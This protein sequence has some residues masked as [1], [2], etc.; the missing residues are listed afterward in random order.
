MGRIVPRCYGS[1][2]NLLGCR[3]LASTGM[4]QC[5]LCAKS[6][7]LVYGLQKLLSVLL[8]AEVLSLLAAKA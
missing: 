1:F 3:L 5:N 8:L 7:L 2:D 4:E 6:T